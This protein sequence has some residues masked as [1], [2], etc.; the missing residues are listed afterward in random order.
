MRKKC[1]DCR[2]YSGGKCYLRTNPVSISVSYSCQY[3]DDDKDW[4][5]N[6]RH[7]KS[8][9]CYLKTPKSISESFKC[10]YYSKFRWGV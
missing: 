1:T 10:Q 6:C 4:C 5:C 9:V 7:F 2:H 3:S 8:R